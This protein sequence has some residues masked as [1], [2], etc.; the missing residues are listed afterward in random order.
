MKLFL[1]SF[2]SIASAAWAEVPGLLRVSPTNSRYFVAEGDPTKAIYMVGSHN[3]QVL[4]D[5]SDQAAFD[6]PGYLAFLQAHNHNFFRM[7]YYDMPHSSVNTQPYFYLSPVPFNRPGPGNT[8]DNSGPKFDMTSFNEAYFTR[9]YERCYQAQQAG[10]YVDIILSGAWWPKELEG[11]PDTSNNHTAW[12]YGYWNPAN[13]VH[14]DPANPYYYITDS[15]GFDLYTKDKAD[16]C[17]TSRENWVALMDG[18][19]EHVVRKVN[20][21]DNVVFEVTNEGAKTSFEWQRHVIAQVRAVEASIPGGKKHLIGF[22]AGQGNFGSSCHTTSSADN[23]TYLNSGADWVSLF[24]HPSEST[25]SGQG[26]PDWPAGAPV[27]PD[28]LDT[29]HS[30]G[31]VSNNVP[32]L[33]RSMMRGHNNWY[34]DVYG[35]WTVCSNGPCP[36]ADENMR[37]VMGYQRLLADRSDLIHAVPVTNGSIVSTGFALINPDSEYIIYQPASGSFTVNLPS[38]KT[39]NYEWIDPVSNATTSGTRSYS[40]GAIPFIAPSGGTS[41]LHLRA[42]LGLTSA[43]SRKTHGGN[44]FDIAL[45]GVEGRS[46]PNHSLVFTFSNPVASGQASVTRGTGTVSGTPVFADK[47]M[48][49]N[50]TGVT[51]GQYIRVALNNVTDSLGQTLPSTSVTAGILHKQSFTLE[52]LRMAGTSGLMLQLAV[53]STERT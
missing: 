23:A 41:V 22:T 5:R 47:T 25:S 36:Q 43:V 45:P 1:L 35:Q 42:A 4:Q 19:I 39:Y 2:L 27:K 29:D 6:Y 37:N 49:V 52:A 3:W 38:A 18:F 33:W 13:N 26:V 51:D 46:G 30:W 31:L 44:Q 20:D 50:L 11:H 10:I 17:A 21:L 8:I 7:W 48:T 28:M 40:A 53:V 34:M 15:H 24:S 12:D 32:Y 9:L 16:S 14:G